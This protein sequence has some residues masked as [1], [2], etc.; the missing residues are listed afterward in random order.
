MLSSVSMK[1]MLAPLSVVTIRNGPPLRRG[2]GQD[3]GQ[4]CRRLGAVAGRYD[5]V[6]E[7]DCHQSSS[8]DTR[9]YQH[10]R[11]VRPVVPSHSIRYKR[12][13]FELVCGARAAHT[14]NVSE[15]PFGQIGQKFSP[16]FKRISILTDSVVRVHDPSHAD[17]YPPSRIQD[18]QRYP[19]FAALV[20]PR[21]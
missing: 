11:P 10:K 8:P 4:E 18:S 3:I 15:H 2:K 7:V 9:L 16:Q 12:Q 17:R 6:I 14:G 5:G 21:K 19:P 1:S 13:Q 20:R